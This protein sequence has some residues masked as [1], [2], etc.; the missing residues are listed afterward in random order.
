MEGRYRIVNMVGKGGFGAVYE[1][2]DERF[3]ARRVVAIKELSDAQLSPPE[4]ITAIQNFRREADL[5]VPLSHPNLPN[6][7]DFF[8]EAGKAYLVMEFIQGKT[9]EKVQEDAGGPLDETR[10]MHCA[11]QLSYL[12][13][14]PQPIIFRDMK[15][16]SMI[17]MKND[18][19]KLVGF[20]IVRFL[21]RPRFSPIPSLPCARQRSLPGIAG[22]VRAAS[23]AS[24]SVRAARRPLR[25]SSRRAGDRWRAGRG[26]RRPR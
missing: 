10:V 18:P 24:G 2:T 6:V 12:H 16:F 1:A 23:S 4:K 17:V 5:L 25:R 21:L 14:Q 8:E 26:R 11:L 7:S 20:S 3:Q 22:W 9:L 15:P 19:I 13:G